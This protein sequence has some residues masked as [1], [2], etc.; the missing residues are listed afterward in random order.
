MESITWKELLS[1]ESRW[2]YL[3][4]CEEREIGGFVP[5]RMYTDPAATEAIRFIRGRRAAT[6]DLLFHEFAAALQF[7]SYFGH[8]W[9]AFDECINDLQDW[10]PATAYVLILTQADQVLAKEPRDFHILVDLLGIAAKEM[11]APR[12]QQGRHPPV[13]FRVVFQCERTKQAECQARLEQAGAE[14]FCR[15]LTIVYD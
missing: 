2:A 15:K 12:D 11:A 10:L 4:H 14:A 5:A 1:A 13:P 6:R 7:P 8:N 9:D 3:V